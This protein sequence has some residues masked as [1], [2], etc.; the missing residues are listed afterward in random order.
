MTLTSGKCLPFLMEK[1]RLSKFIIKVGC[2][3]VRAGDVSWRALPVASNNVSLMHQAFLKERHTNICAG[4]LGKPLP[5]RRLQIDCDFLLIQP[6]I[7]K[8]LAD[9]SPC[10]HKALLG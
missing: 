2:H 10:Y 6:D 3:F 5:G 1:H 9:P 8:F 4:S 7:C